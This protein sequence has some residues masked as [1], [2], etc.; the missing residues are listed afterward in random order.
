MITAAQAL[1]LVKRSDAEVER[2][3]ALIGPAIE[4]ASKAGR[5]SILLSSVVGFPDPAAVSVH[6]PVN[7][8]FSM[9]DFQTRLCAALKQFGFGADMQAPHASYVPRGLAD[10]DGNGPSYKH[11]TIIVRW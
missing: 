2:Y 11:Y 4:V 5:R 9:T 3:L 10:D 6:L 7:T 1:E 8:P